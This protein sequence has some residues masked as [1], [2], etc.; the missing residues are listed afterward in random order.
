MKNKNKLIGIFY[1]TCIII[2]FSCRENQKCGAG[3]VSNGRVEFYICQEMFNQDTII[4]SDNRWFAESDFVE[5]QDWVEYKNVPILERPPIVSD[6]WL[7]QFDTIA[8]H[9]PNGYKII[10]A[11]QSF[12]IVPSIWAKDEDE[13][14]QYMDFYDL[15]MYCNDPKV[16]KLK[17]N[18][19]LNPLDIDEKFAYELY[20]K[21]KSGI[22][23]NQLLSSLK[24]QFDASELDL[25]NRKIDDFT[26]ASDK[27][28][29]LEKN[30]REKEIY[31]GYLKN[32]INWEKAPKERFEL[33]A[34]ERY[35]TLSIQNGEKI[36]KLTLIYKPVYGN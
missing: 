1:A 31:I 7:G 2:M 13:V 18:I 8:F 27:K 28:E 17:N 30:Q 10:E 3:K 6:S 4:N 33:L 36:N 29:Y 22:N 25:K 23:K 20:F 5:M 16:L 24:K 26:S 11:K 34:V 35:L 14:V 21:S 15:K 32:Y 12:I 19:L 9:L